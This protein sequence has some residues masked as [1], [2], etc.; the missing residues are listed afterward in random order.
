MPDYQEMYVKLFRAT[1]KAMNVLI[2]AQRECEER[3][4]SAPDADFGDLQASNENPCTEKQKAV[5]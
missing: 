1:E 3:Y 4:I 5:T 2:E